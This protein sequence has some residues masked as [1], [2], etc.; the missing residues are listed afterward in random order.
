MATSLPAS[1]CG[2]RDTCPQ[3]RGHT[4]N[5]RPESFPAGRPI[6][7]HVAGHQA[8]HPDKPGRPRNDRT[9]LNTSPQPL[10]P[11]LDRG[12][13][14]DKQEPVIPAF[15]DAAA[16][17]RRDSPRPDSAGVG[18]I[19]LADV[20]RRRQWPAAP[21]ALTDLGYQSTLMTERYGRGAL[22]S[23]LSTKVTIRRSDWSSLRLPAAHDEV[24]HPK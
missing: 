6:N 20:S 1:S 2:S 21:H 3:R 23:A 17:F 13:N 9:P 18:A 5:E 22:Y 11:A 24:N 12:P 4:K 16:A 19:M 14:S 8:E 10:T 7:H 15:H